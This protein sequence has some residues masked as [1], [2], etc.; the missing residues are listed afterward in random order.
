MGSLYYDQYQDFLDRLWSA[1]F[2]GHIGT[3]RMLLLGDKHFLQ[4]VNEARKTDGNTQYLWNKTLHAGATERELAS[5]AATPEKKVKDAV[6]KIL[7]RYPAQIYWFFP[8]ASGY[9]R[10]GIPDI[11][12]CVK[13]NF[14]GIECKAKNNTPT[15]LQLFNLERI[16]DTGGVSMVISGPE[17]VEGLSTIIDA[18]CKQESE[19]GKE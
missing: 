9:G 10:V 3:A 15:Q 5:M 14:W 16:D 8:V 2:C 1:V 19:D 13:G 6:I 11:V 4:A 7:N 12:A 18:M 17:E